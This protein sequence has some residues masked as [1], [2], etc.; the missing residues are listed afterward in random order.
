MPPTTT[1]KVA[2]HAEAIRPPVRS[3]SRGPPLRT[4]KLMQTRPR[5]DR[6]LVLDDRPRR[7]AAMS[8]P[9]AAATAPQAA[10]A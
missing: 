1:E 2:P 9:P 5:T 8:A 7:I 10:G 6:D 4:R 3:P